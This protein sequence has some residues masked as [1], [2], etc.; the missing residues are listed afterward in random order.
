MA[1]WMETWEASSL[2]A[3]LATMNKEVDTEQAQKVCNTSIP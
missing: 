1:G 3:M 2:A